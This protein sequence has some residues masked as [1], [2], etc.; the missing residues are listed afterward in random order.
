[1]LV[2]SDG[3]AKRM[4]LGTLFFGL[5][6][7]GS[8]PK[9][10]DSLRSD[11]DSKDAKHDRAANAE[12]VRHIASAPP[13]DYY[14]LAMNQTLSEI[15]SGAPKPSSN[16]SYG[17]NT[18]MP[19]NQN[20]LLW[21]NFGGATV[22]QGFEPGQTFLS[23]AATV[24]IP[25]A[26]LSAGEKGVILNR[27][28]G[29]FDASGVNLTVIAQKPVGGSYTTV[30]IGG[31]YRD[32]GCGDK[33]V[34]SAGPFDVFNINANDTVF[35]FSDGVSDFDLFG[36]E[37]AHQVGHS[38]GL[39]HVEDPEAVMHPQVSSATLGFGRA[40]ITGGTRIQDSPA[41]LAR[42]LSQSNTDAIPGLE[43]LPPGLANLPGISRIATIAKLFASLDSKDVLDITTFIP[44]LQAALPPIL[45][46][47]LPSGLPGLDRV[48]TIISLANQAG[49]SN[50]S[51][52][53]TSGTVA[54]SPLDK[55][56]SIFSGG[57]AGQVLDGLNDEALKDGVIVL[58]TLAGYGNVAIAIDLAADLLGQVLGLGQQ[59]TAN[60]KTSDQALPPVEQLVP[61]LVTLLNLPSFSQD[62]A[63]FI[64]N[65]RDTITLLGTQ[66]SDDQLD[67]LFTLLAVAYGQA[68][69]ASTQP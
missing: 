30:H 37:I 50:D 8:S 62:P 18:V 16:R 51:T 46:G 22:A 27:V 58:A 7:C 14:N 43:K 41:M 56:G 67:A 21:L 53:N 59:T 39:A 65:L 13:I 25:P 49:Q 24:T 66:N 5:T 17:L 35:A 47:Q 19:A 10:S 55:L 9:L 3:V 64:K 38:Y 29:L 33:Q 26:Q 61:D 6:G 54:N 12:S 34:R 52:A 28:Q 48:I 31:R 40:V 4:L 60:Q 32:L 57:L 45:A 1:M 20:A 15:S 44:A 36:N 68:H 63:L 42:A 69:H 2:L 23:C 11:S